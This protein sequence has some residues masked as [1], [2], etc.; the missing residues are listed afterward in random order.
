MRQFSIVV[1]LVGALDACERTLASVL[2]TRPPGSQIIAPH[3]PEYGDPWRIA[4]EV[5]LL[6]APRKATSADQLVLAGLRHSTGEFVT[7]LGPGLDLPEG[8]HEAVAGAFPDPEVAA[9]GATVGVPVGGSIVI[10]PALAGVD[11]TGRPHS[12][13]PGCAGKGSALVASGPSLFAATFRGEA[14]GWLP[15]EQLGLMPGSLAVELALALAALG[16]R[17]ITCRAWYVL[18]EGAQAEDR[19]PGVSSGWLA[20]R[21]ARRFPELIG[22]SRTIRLL[23]DF[24]TGQW[25]RGAGRLAAIPHQESDRLFAKSMARIRRERSRLIRRSEPESQAASFRRA[26]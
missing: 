24:C 14:L 19:C 8:W 23:Q 1:P 26:A 2:R 7:V 13:A 15:L 25:S 11:R 10:G 3:A 4:N 6:P 20:E 17:C 12:S 5:E 21:L 9:I 22:T 18:A 16:S